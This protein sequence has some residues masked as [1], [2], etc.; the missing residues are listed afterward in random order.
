MEFERVINGIV[1]F[2]NSEMYKGMNDWQ[3]MIARIAVARVVNN[4][5][6][7]KSALCNNGFVRTFA[8]IDENG[9][10][11]VDG[12]MRDIK[13][14]FNHKEKISFSLPMFGTF[15][16]TSDDIDKLHRMINEG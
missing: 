10:V 14:Q 15:T 6:N 7:I 16:F 9:I 11:D 4:S 13:S 5:E 12:L 2:I 3:E 8:V 1:R